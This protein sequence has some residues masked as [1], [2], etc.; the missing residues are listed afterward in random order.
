MEVYIQIQS[1]VRVTHECEIAEPTCKP[2][3]VFV[4]GPE[5]EN[6]R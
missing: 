6:K 1:R 5:V 2:N 4:S 3:S